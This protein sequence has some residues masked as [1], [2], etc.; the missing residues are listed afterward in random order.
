MAN[1]NNTELTPPAIP[2]NA[3]VAQQVANEMLGIESASHT[4]LEDPIDFV[5]RENGFTDLSSNNSVIQREDSI[6]V[7]P[8]NNQPSE[9]RPVID[10]DYVEAEE[11]EMDLLENNTT[12]SEEEQAFLDAFLQE[13]RESLEQDSLEQGRSR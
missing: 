7:V 3:D 5:L 12:I 2:E 13:Q 8:R 4:V 11:V 10:G 9:T 1:I 6:V